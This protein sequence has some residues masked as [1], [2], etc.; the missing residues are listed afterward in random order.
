MQDMVAVKAR[1]TEL[2]TLVTELRQQLAE[3]K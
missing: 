3:G 1:E 2:E